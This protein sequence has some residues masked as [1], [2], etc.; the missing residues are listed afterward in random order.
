[1]QVSTSTKS[2]FHSLEEG[3]LVLVRLR[4]DDE[5][6]F[7]ALV[8]QVSDSCIDVIRSCKGEQLISLPPDTAL[9]KPLRASDISAAVRE[10]LYAKVEKVAQALL[11]ECN[12]AANDT[13]TTLNSAA[14]INNAHDSIVGLS[15]SPAVDTGHLDE[16]NAEPTAD[17]GD[18]IL[19]GDLFDGSVNESVAAMSP[20]PLMTYV[21]ATPASP[22]EETPAASTATD[23]SRNEASKE[24]TDLS[25]TDDMD[26]LDCEISEA[27][28]TVLSLESD[29]SDYSMQAG[30]RVGN[31]GSVPAAGLE[32]DVHTRDVNPGLSEAD[33]DVDG[34]AA[35][36]GGDGTLAASPYLEPMDLD[37]EEGVPAFKWTDGVSATP[38][39]G[40]GRPI[41]EGDEL[42]HAIFKG[43]EMKASGDSASSDLLFRDS[44]NSSEPPFLHL[45]EP[46]GS[47]GYKAMAAALPALDDFISP[48]VRT[49]LQQA[50]A[51]QEDLR[52]PDMQAGPQLGCELR[53]YQKQ[54]LSWLLRQYDKGLNCILGD[55]PSIGRRIQIIAF[56]SH[57]VQVRRIFGFHLVVAPVSE[58]LHWESEIGRWCPELRVLRVHTSH[59]E[60]L[61]WFESVISSNSINSFTGGDADTPNVVVTSFSM[62]KKSSADFLRKITWE[63][64]VFDVKGRMLRS[65]DDPSFRACAK[66]SA[67]CRVI[68]S[69]DAP[70]IVGPVVQFLHQT[71]ACLRLLHPDIFYDIEPFI[72]HCN[73]PSRSFYL[74]LLISA[75]ILQYCVLQTSGLR[76]GI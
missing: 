76:V 71:H 61:Q 29:G 67:R 23:G 9:L 10:N 28:P 13:S 19:T 53:E 16:S 21:Y 56:L 7:P 30:R 5:D 22:V 52:G 41:P 64:V 2:I 3:S 69:S 44:D 54:G 39:D 46:A 62:L 58:M 20:Q 43:L 26:G 36:I 45:R 73:S 37:V 25:L 42:C 47:R 51:P 74:H 66:L 27:E 50:L 59:Q 33:A 49:F 14:I 63:S 75:D 32:D 24:G 1:M 57:L 70:Q 72:A 11:I 60:Y 65:I 48:G 68:L 17:P 35:T 31:D 38:T 40:E 34:A 4:G 15:H 8:I 18:D 12:G 55:E 6:F